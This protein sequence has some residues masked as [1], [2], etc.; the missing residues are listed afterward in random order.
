LGIWRPG[1]FLNTH[2]KF[3]R[4]VWQ[5]DLWH[6]NTFQLVINYVVQLMSKIIVIK[7]CASLMIAIFVQTTG[8]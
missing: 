8:M 7:I 6:A 5:V 1:R 2:C 3:N 4:S